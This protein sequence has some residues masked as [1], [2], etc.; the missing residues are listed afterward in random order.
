LTRP[1]WS[2]SLARA[3]ALG[4]WVENFLLTSLLAAL[5]GFAGLQILLRNLFSAGLPWADGLV[6]LIVLWVAVIGAV[7][8]TRDDRQ[9]AINLAQRFL[10]RVWR[11]PVAIIVYLFAASIAGL[12]SWYSLQFVRDSMQYGDTLLGQWPAWMLQAVM[13]VGFALMSYRFLLRCLRRSSEAA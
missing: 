9:I 2:R 11:R 7:A 6:R 3:E 13:P 12:L 5:I 1:A 8:A 4:R 10:P